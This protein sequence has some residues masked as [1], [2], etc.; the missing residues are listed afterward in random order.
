MSV[1]ATPYLWIGNRDQERGGPNRA[2]RIVQEHWRPN[3]VA[4]TVHSGQV[5][6]LPH[7]KSQD[8]FY[9]NL[10]SALEGVHYRQRRILNIWRRLMHHY[11]LRQFGLG[12]IVAIS[13]RTRADLIK[14]NKTENQMQKKMIFE[15]TTLYQGLVGDHE[16]RKDNKQRAGFPQWEFPLPPDHRGA[17]PVRRTPAGP[18]WMIQGRAYTA[19]MFTSSSVTPYSSPLATRSAT[20][21]AVT[22]SSPPA[23]PS[24]PRLEHILPR[25]K[26]RR[27][28]AIGAEADVITRA[29]TL[30]LWYT[31]FVNPVLATATLMSEVH[32]SWIKARDDISKAGNIEASDASLKL[33]S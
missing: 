14:L 23:D 2:A 28:I 1:H 11:K 9:H 13:T 6:V 19:P 21:S 20:T 33:V 30:I 25:S 17:A 22:S 15:M 31:L 32:R 4:L 27:N 8:V 16:L 26:S 24:T 10:R 12:M 29:K 18:Q 7:H 5:G 3:Q